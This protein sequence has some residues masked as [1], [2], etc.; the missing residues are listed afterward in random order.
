MPG[1]SVQNP[2]SNILLHFALAGCLCL[3]S[4]AKEQATAPLPELGTPTN[5][6]A[7][8]IADTLIQIE[9]TDASDIET[10]Y[11]VERNEK[12]EG[13]VEI[14]RTPANVTMYSDTGRFRA[15][16]TYVY[17][18]KTFT[19]DRT[20][21][22]SDSASIVVSYSLSAPTSLVCTV[23][24]STSAKVEWRDNCLLE[25]GFTIERNVDDG[26]FYEIGTV[27]ANHTAFT[28]NEF[29]YGPFFSYRVRAF[30]AANQGKPSLP[31][32]VVRIPE[33]LFPL[34]AGHVLRY[35]GYLIRYPDTKVESSE[36]GYQADVTVGPV[37]AINTVYPNPPT[38]VTGTGTIVTDSTDVPGGGIG[39]LRMT[40]FFDYDPA[41]ARH[42]MLMNVG[43]FFRAFGINRSDSL[44]YMVL[45]DPRQGFQQSYT[46][47]ANT[48][49]ALVG[50]DLI[51]VELRYTG[52]WVSVDTI[53]TPVGNFKTWEL[54]V[55]QTVSV[56]TTPVV[57]NVVL[58]FWFAQGVGP[59]KMIMSGNVEQ[60]GHAR[61]LTA[62]NF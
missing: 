15:E 60:Y 20:S 59:V 38:D 12:A 47:L 25:R 18:V 55:V 5:V 27:I 39:G 8:L 23:L 42:R 4:C 49:A 16:S 61:V 13:F 28:D 50:G 1:G 44:Q 51:D 48:Y 19:A 34:T 30:S 58:H 14:A 9:W 33:D 46:C 45:T 36:P 10:G 21:G 26:P 62:K 24:S 52:K 35:S 22:Y 2:H 32:D 57:V 56:G 40:H 7:T 3:F 54:E 11:A 31:I 17:R 43:Y 29:S 37:V 41:T 6:R 53:Q